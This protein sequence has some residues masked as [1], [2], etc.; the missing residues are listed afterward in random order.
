MG[1]EIF[2]YLGRMIDR[3]DD[4]WPAVDHNVIKALQVWI[5]IG[6]MIWR[7]EAYPLVSEMFYWAVLQAVLLFGA[8]TWVLLA[9]MSKNLEGVHMEFLRKVSGNTAKRQ[10]DGTYISAAVES[11]IKEAII[12]S[13]GA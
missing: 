4:D 9:G 13:L 6:K 3:S 8:E 10:R 5:W 1:V 2:N 7:K 12:M 11:V